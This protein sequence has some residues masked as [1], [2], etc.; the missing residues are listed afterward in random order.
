MTFVLGLFIHSWKLIKGLRRNSSLVCVSTR[1]LRISR[2]H[3]KF[4]QLYWVIL[5]PLISF[6]EE[7][8]PPSSA[9]PK[10]SYT[11][12]TLDEDP[13]EKINRPIFEFNRVVDGILFDPVAVMYKGALP[14]VVQERISNFLN[15]MA[16]PLTFTND[17]LQAKGNRALES[18]CRFFLNT[19]FGL[20]GLFDVADKMG[21]PLH[22]EDFN[23]TLKYW[24]VP[25][26]P[27][28]VL[29]ILG[30]ASPRF[31]VG[32]TADYFVD[33]FNYYFTQNDE[34]GLAYSRTG[35]LFIKAR[36]AIVDD[37]RNFRETSLDF[38]AAMRSFYKQY[39]NVDRQGDVITYS[40]PSLEEFMLGDE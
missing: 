20:F 34:A 31:I 33:P 38:Y 40:S 21:L 29:P 16:E 17:C 14:I 7:V 27:Y 25:Q 26:G 37:I 30:P 15:N 12:D 28:I 22:K 2:P 3:F 39:M 23:T 5:F 1:S 32:L 19:V 13:L 9:K 6:A 4:S 10:V 24:G 36:A 35:V 18:F 8:S 11:Y